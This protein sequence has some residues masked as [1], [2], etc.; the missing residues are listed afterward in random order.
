MLVHCV[1][2]SHV[3]FFSG[4][5]KICEDSY[6]VFRPKRVGAHL[7]YSLG[8]ANHIA[9][10]LLFSH[11]NGIPKEDK[12]LLSFGEIDIRVHVVRQSVKQNKSIKEIVKNIVVR[13][14]RAIDAL[15]GNSHKIVIWSPVPTCNCSNP[16]AKVTEK[17]PYP[18]IGT[19]QQRNEANLYFSEFLRKRY[20]ESVPVLD[21]YKEIIR[22]DL[23]TRNEYF[24]DSIH[25]SQKAMPLILKKFKRELFK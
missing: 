19:T 11:V 6:M 4:K 5:N 23:T 15:I 3:C 1:G 25:L 12:L 10:R 20:G 16:K 8:D 2:D 13:Y 22:Q 7:A 18:H 21:L 14:C 24:M 17:N 9:S